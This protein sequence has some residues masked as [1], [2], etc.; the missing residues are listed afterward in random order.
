MK[1]KEQKVLDIRDP[2]RIFL[3]DD[4]RLQID[5]DVII[6]ILNSKNAFGR[7]TEA[8]D[9]LAWQVQHVVRNIELKSDKEL[10]WIIELMRKTGAVLLEKDP[11]NPVGRYIEYFLKEY[12]FLRQAKM[13][14][15][16]KT[17]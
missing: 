16:L 10:H 5:D 12:D 8:E 11:L 13:R 3:D 14:N 9:E 15:Y 6:D 2:N 17:S 4:E 1:K 7:L